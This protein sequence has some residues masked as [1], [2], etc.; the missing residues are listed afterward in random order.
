MEFL[1]R[2]RFTAVSILML[3]I[4]AGAITTPPLTVWIMQTIGWRWAFVIP[5]ALGFSWVILSRR[6]FRQP[7][8]HPTIANDEREIILRERSKQ[9]GRES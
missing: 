6:C 5:G 9:I 4:G 1:D 7:E 8:D 2:E 3:R